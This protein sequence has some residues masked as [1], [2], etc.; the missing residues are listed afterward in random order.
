MLEDPK[1][2]I[3]IGPKSALKVHEEHVRGRW[4]SHKGIIFHGFLCSE[5]LSGGTH[6]ELTCCRKPAVKCE[7]GGSTPQRMCVSKESKEAPT[8][9]R[10]R[11]L[12]R[13]SGPCS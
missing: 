10:R 9:L 7:E 13:H 11:L 8:A 2:K 3:A 1:T 12:G 4:V 5:S 6:L